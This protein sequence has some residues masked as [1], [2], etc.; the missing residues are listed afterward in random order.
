MKRDLLA[1]VGRLAT[2]GRRAFGVRDEQFDAYLEDIRAEAK[3]AMQKY[4]MLVIPGAEITQNRL[5]G[6]KNSHVIALDIRKYIS[7]DQRA[8]APRRRCDGAR[9]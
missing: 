9:S 6:R 8:D 7:A 5:S 3:R 4:G 1:R 2:F